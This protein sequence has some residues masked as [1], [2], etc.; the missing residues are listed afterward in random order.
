[1]KSTTLWKLFTALACVALVSKAHAD[2]EDFSPSLSAQAEIAEA[3]ADIESRN[4]PRRTTVKTRRL[5]RPQRHNT[6]SVN[7]LRTSSEMTTIYEQ[8]EGA[9]FWSVA[10]VFGVTVSTM[11]GTS[12]SYSFEKKD[13][14]TGGLSVL[15]GT[16]N[17]QLETGLHYSERGGIYTYALNNTKWAF[18]FDNKYIEVPALLRLK[19]KILSR[20]EVFAKGG[21]VVG[22]LQD[23]KATLGNL[24][25]YYGSSYSSTDSKE[26][27]N[28][29]DVRWSLGLGTAVKVSQS[30]ALTLQADYQESFENASQSQPTAWGGTTHMNLSNSTYSFGGGILVEI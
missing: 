11:T 14:Y 16:G 8:E 23:S 13:G 22:L 5:Q 20:M 6:D 29:T 28:S 7:S 2:D 26:H 19:F 21:V 4:S 18:E 30:V 24:Q 1:M 3:V 12:G 17:L 25:N 10:P 9:S 15:L 27:F